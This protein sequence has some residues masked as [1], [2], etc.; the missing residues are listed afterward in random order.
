VIRPALEQGR[1][2]L[3][4]RFEMSTRAYQGAGRGLPLP[5][6]ENAIALA[7]GDTRP[8]LYIVLDIAVKESRNRQ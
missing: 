6:V 1:V 7:V 2:V 4:D 3:A 8:S 5:L